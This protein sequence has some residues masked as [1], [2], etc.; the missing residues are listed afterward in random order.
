MGIDPVTLA[1]V[2]S[3][4]AGAGAVQGMIA[5]RNQAAYEQKLAQRNA[6]IAEDNARTAIIDS[7]EEQQDWSR[8]ARDQ[9]GQMVA[10]MGASG[11]SLDTG[12]NLLRRQSTQQDVVR[13]AQRIRQEGNVRADAYRNQKSNFIG[14]ASAASARKRNATVEGALNIGSTLIGGA[15]SVNKARTAKALIT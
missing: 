6:L 11:V 15:T 10:E 9:I 5:A 4:V 8:S 13:D 14:E 7:Q 1:I 3:V 2:G 12:T